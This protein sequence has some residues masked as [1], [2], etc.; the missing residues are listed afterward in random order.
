VSGISCSLDGGPYQWH[1]GARAVLPVSGLGTHS[2][3]CVAYNDAID[4]YGRVATSPPASFTMSIRDQ[5]VMGAWTQTE[6]NPPNCHYGLVTTHTR[7]RWVTIHVHGRP[8]WVYRH[9]HVVKHKKLICHLRT[10][11]RRTVVWT[12]VIK[13]GHKVKVARIRYVRIVLPPTEA[14]STTATAEFGRGIELQGW[15]GLSAYV[16]AGVQPVDIV[17]SPDNGSNAFTTVATTV[18]NA[19]GSWFAALPPGPS[20]IVEAVFPGSDTLEPA[21]SNEIRVTVPADVQLHIHPHR[22]QWGSTIRI[23][24]QLL[25]GY[26]PPSGELVLLRI[27]WPG[28][29]TEIG[30]VMT[31]SSGRFSAPYTFLRGSGT[32]HYWIWAQSARESDYPFAPAESRQIPITVTQR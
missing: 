20:R 24:G 18:T 3:T 9:G 1:A 2:A 5:M 19:D 14:N 21:T 30:H 22:T 17:A 10:A 12:T 27:G 11:R 23:S 26:I 16:S 15:L 8:V 13:D 32:E 6:R 7:G 25:G 31:D 29:S 4:S 28:G